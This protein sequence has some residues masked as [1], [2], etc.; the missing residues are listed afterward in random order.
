MKMVR[1]GLDCESPRVIRE[2]PEAA[3][4]AVSLRLPLQTDPTARAA[5]SRENLRRPPGR[6]GRR[7]RILGW[8][9]EPFQDQGLVGAGAS[10]AAAA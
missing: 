3:Q 1:S 10:A 6:A 5:V 4:D 2:E 9:R 8:T 7:R